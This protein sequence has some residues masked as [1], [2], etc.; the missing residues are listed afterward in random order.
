MAF[1]QPKT[2]TKT[3]DHPDVT[4]GGLR[5]TAATTPGGLCDVDNHFSSTYINHT[6]S[7]FGYLCILIHI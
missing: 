7:R 6:L 4:A 5:P 1:P 2:V 3:G